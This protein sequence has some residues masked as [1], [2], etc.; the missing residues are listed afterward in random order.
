MKKMS[1]NLIFVSCMM[2]LLASSFSTFATNVNQNN[3][4]KKA[5]FKDDKDAEM[6]LGKITNISGDSMTIELA[7][8]VKREKKTTEEKK[9]KNIKQIK[10]KEKNQ[11]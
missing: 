1:K 11:L 8:R 6:V 4:T 10:Q 5:S 2:M 3:E 7:N 9:Q